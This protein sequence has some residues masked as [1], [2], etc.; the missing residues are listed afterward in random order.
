MLQIQNLTLTHATDLRVLVNQLHLTIERGDKVAIIGDEGNGKSSLLNTLFQAPDYPDHLLV[1]GHITHSYSSHGYLPQSLPEELADLS[2]ADYFFGP[3]DSDPDYA[4]IYRYAD[5]LAFDTSRL[6]SK[7]QIGSLS[8]GERL[9]VQLIK[10]LSLHTDVLFLDEP[11]ND[12]DLT[13]LVWLEQF[14]QKSPKTIIFVSHDEVFLSKTAN[15]IIHLESVKKKTVA[16]TTVE[17][18]EYQA[19]RTQREAAYQK[20]VLQARN[21]QKEYDKARTKHLRQKSQVRTALVR[22]HDATQGRLL[23]KKMKSVLAREKRY[24]KRKEN[25][26]QL[27]YHEDRIDLSLTSLRPLP[28]NKQILTLD[29]Y[30]LKI[31]ETE[32][33][34]SRLSLTIKATDKIGIIGENGVGKSTLLKVI[35]QQLQARKDLRLGYLPQNY[36]D[37]LDKEK[38]PYAFLSEGNKVTIQQE[39]LNLLANL[40][41]TRQEVHQPIHRLSGGQQAKVLLVNLLIQQAN[42]LLLDEPSRNFSPTSQ[43][44]IRQLFADFRGGLVCV[45]HD[46][47]F[48][49]QVCDRLYSLSPQGLLALDQAVLFGERGQ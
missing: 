32:Q 44:A 37:V 6:T 45:S 28:A 24:E 35:H 7:Q 26:T 38:S 11:S 19:Y 43:P 10:L 23:A 21:E 4:A 5:Q 36:E 12:L 49:S 2:L 17:R 8:G 47:E 14:I 34:L 13:T 31:P 42:F 1:Q 15:K 40:Q 48:L 41:F 29:H 22:A 33:D 30:Q 46:R 9:K 39:I 16:Q 18:K 20:Q 3:A 27:P 25:L